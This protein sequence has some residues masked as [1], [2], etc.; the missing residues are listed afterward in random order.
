MWRKHFKLTYEISKD[1]LDSCGCVIKS[2]GCPFKKIIGQE[3]SSRSDIDMYSSYKLLCLVVHAYLTS[4]SF[5]TD[6]LC[7]CIQQT[8]CLDICRRQAWY[9]CSKL[10]AY[11]CTSSIFLRSCYLMGNTRYTALES[12]K[13]KQKQYK[14]TNFG[15]FDTFFL[16]VEQQFVPEMF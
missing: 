9:Q 15:P 6:V 12:M 7:Y 5:F 10:A 1:R 2:Y 13:S 3:I 16:H 4:I 11:F 8:L 14:S